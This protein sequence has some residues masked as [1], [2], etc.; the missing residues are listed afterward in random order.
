[1]AGIHPVDYTAGLL[2]V[3]LLIYV[4]TKYNDV[5]SAK[6][7]QQQREDREK[8]IAR[9]TKEERQELAEKEKAE[10]EKHDREYTN[11]LREEQL[12]E[13]EKQLARQAAELKKQEK[14]QGQIL[15]PGQ[16]LAAKTAASAYIGYK[17][18]KKIAKW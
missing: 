18:G 3:V 6:E 8:K 14:A 16:K 11:W 7:R 9:M 15:S 12:K 4:V 1:L 2:F 13:K 5:Q 17:L 10:K